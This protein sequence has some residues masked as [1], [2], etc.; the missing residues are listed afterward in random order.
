MNG[1]EGKEAAER[2]RI[3]SESISGEGIRE[4]LFGDGLYLSAITQ[5][6]AGARK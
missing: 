4:D 5:R 6:G 1:H 2:F 3:G